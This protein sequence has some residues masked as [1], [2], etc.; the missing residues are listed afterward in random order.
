ML[1]TTKHHPKRPDLPR[2]QSGWPIIV[3]FWFAE[4]AGEVPPK[5]SVWLAYN[6]LVWSA[7]NRGLKGREKEFLRQLGESR[8]ARVWM[9]EDYRTDIFQA[10]ASAQTFIESVLT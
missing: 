1:L 4:T 10:I 8:V 6:R 7:R 3:P 2:S 5:K 9:N